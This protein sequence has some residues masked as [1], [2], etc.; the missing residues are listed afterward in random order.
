MIELIIVLAAIIVIE[1]A[2]IVRQGQFIDTL[3]DKYLD[4]V[5][6]L[7][8]YEPNYSYTER[9]DNVSDDDLYI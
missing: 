5:T 1:G 9:W 3:S 6:E 2:I 8:I 4:A 7:E